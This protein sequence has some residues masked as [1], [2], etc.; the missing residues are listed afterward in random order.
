MFSIIFLL[1]SLAAFAVQPAP[2]QPQHSKV[3]VCSGSR[4]LLQGS[5][6]VKECAYEVEVKYGGGR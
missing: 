4:E 5:G 2:A 1:S 3:W 6:T